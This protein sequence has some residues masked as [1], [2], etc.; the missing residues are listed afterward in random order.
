M[1]N[2]PEWVNKSHHE[3]FQLMEQNRQY[4]CDN[5]IT[6]PTNTKM[7]FSLDG[8]YITD[9]PS[10][11][12]SIGEAING[13]GG[14]FGA[15]LDSLSDCLLGGFGVEDQI[16]IL[17]VNAGNLEENLNFSAWVRFKLEQKLSLFQE[18]Q[19]SMEELKE[20]EIGEVMPH[21]SKTYIEHLYE[22]FGGLLKIYD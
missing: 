1:E 14:Y 2:K 20:W 16:E 13:I 18:Y 12:L 7:S 10:F 5:K 22:I 11:Y 17:I 15:C 9:I 19:P 8:S 21:G 6:Y 3:K 4:M